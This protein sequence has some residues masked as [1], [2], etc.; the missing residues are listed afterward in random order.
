MLG[1]SV[2]A[3]LTASTSAAFGMDVEPAADDTVPGPEHVHAMMLR[4]TQVP[5]SS[6]LT[7]N[8]N[9]PPQA[10]A[11]HPNVIASASLRVIVMRLPVF[12]NNSPASS[13]RTTPR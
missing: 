13:C 10:S 8:D 9:L 4:K 2:T 12:S 6:T 3:C 7:L 1:S 5:E 11:R